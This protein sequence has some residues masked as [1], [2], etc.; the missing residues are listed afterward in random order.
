MQREV[1]QLRQQ[2]YSL[3]AM[4]SH[5][6]HKE[7]REKRNCYGTQVREAKKAHWD[8]WIKEANAADTWTISKYTKAGSLDGSWAHIPPLQRHLGQSTVQDNKAKGELL[9]KM[10]FPKP[11][12][13]LMVPNDGLQRREA[14]PFT[15][16]TDKQI[17]EGCRCLREFK[18]ARPDGIPNEVYKRCEDLLIPF[19]GPIFQATFDLGHYPAAWKCSTTVVVRK[20]GCGDYSLT[21]SYHPIALM[22]CMGKILSSCVARAVEHNMEILGLYPEHHFGGR[23]GRTT[24]DSLHL[25]TK[26]VKDV[27]RTRKAASILFL[28]IEAAFPSATPEQLYDKMGWMGIPAQIIQW[29]DWKMMGRRTQISFDDFTSEL[30]EITSGIDQGFPLSI[31]LY[32]IY[33]SLL[34]E[35]ADEEDGET[36]LGFIDDVAVIAV[37]KNLEQTSAMLQSHIKRQG[38]AKEWLRKQNSRFELSKLCLVHAE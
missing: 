38:G 34:L 13:K 8:A 33:N 2:H 15:H 26:T 3:R 20:P 9:Y 27:W 18:A 16:I 32:K 14:F 22:N 6:I 36:S 29:M 7:Y 31:F 25:L 5:P 28:D 10:F 4:P 17:R 21:K 19:L 12:P 30:F 11:P 24:T 35:M 1:A 37:G 23:A